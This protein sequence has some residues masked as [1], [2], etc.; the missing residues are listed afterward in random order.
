MIKSSDNKNLL[1]NTL[2]RNLISVRQIFAKNPTFE[3]LNLTKLKT[4]NVDELVGTAVKN[5]T[6]FCNSQIL[7]SINIHIKLFSSK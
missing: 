6:L 5:S 1:K 3:I 4:K 2:A 7:D